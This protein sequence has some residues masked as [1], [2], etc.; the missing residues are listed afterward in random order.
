[1]PD[2]SCVMNNAW[3]IRLTAALGFGA[4]ALG[5]F[6]AHGLEEVLTKNQTTDIWETAVFY[7]FV[8][9]PI[10]IFLTRSE[11][12]TSGPFWSFLG[13]ILVFSGTLYVLAVTNVK[14]LGAITPIGG[15]AFLV[16]WFWIL[17]SPG[18][19]QLRS[20]IQTGSR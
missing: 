2:Y 15:L 5:A 4:V 14:W 10:L 1:M 9:L 7:H 6:G 12:R 18:L 19:L 13:G 17:L 11:G 3:M 16:G 8:H 20:T